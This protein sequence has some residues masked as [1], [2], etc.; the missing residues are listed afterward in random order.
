MSEGEEF[1][2]L[3]A[4]HRTRLSIPVADTSVIEWLGVQDNVSA[5]IRTLIRDHIA[6]HG[7]SDPTCRPVEQRPRRGRP[8]GSKDRRQRR[9]RLRELKA[10]S[11]AAKAEHEAAQERHD[12]PG[13]NEHEHSDVEFEDA[14]EHEGLSGLHGHIVG[15]GEAEHQPWQVTTPD[16]QPHYDTTYHHFE[17]ENQ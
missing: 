3:A 16:H 6:A 1:A 2:A 13:I 5:S 8:P 14:P 15:H 10:D 7:M 11:D 12:G 4:P 9:V 17:G